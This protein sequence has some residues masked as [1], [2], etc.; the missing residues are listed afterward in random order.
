MDI[1]EGSLL[2]EAG[3]HGDTLASFSATAGKYGLSALCFH[4]CTKT[5]HLGATATVGLESALRHGL[6]WTPT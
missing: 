5:V 1:S 6:V 2:A 4:S 3:L